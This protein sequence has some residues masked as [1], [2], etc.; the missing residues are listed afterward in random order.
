M[1]ADTIATMEEAQEPI[2]QLKYTFSVVLPVYDLRHYGEGVDSLEAAAKAETLSL[3][4][5]KVDPADVLS[6]GEQFVVSVEVEKEGEVNGTA[7]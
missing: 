3:N 4:E 2:G 6:Y 7:C 5:G 1:D